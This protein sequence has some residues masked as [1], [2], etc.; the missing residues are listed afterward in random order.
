MNR[1]THAA[2]AFALSFLI[3]STALANG[4]FKPHTFASLKFSV[5]APAG[6]TSLEQ[7]VK[8]TKFKFDKIGHFKVTRKYKAKDL[9]DLAN[10][11][12]AKEGQGAWKVKKETRLKIN[13]NDALMMSLKLKAKVRMLYYFINTKNGIYALSFA[14]MKPQ[15]K[16]QKGI[17]HAVALSFKAL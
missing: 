5:T 13:G 17:Y 12:R 1:K 6:W 3:A 8:H 16:K 7:T 11:M 10:I 9:N 4:A 14:N 2:L 15:F